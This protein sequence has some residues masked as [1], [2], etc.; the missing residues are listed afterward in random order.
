MSDIR[1][2]SF[3][4]NL[5]KKIAA[6]IFKSVGL[7]NQAASHHQH[8]VPHD[9]GWAIKG[10]GNSRYTEIFDRQSAAI[11][12]ATEIAENYKADVIIHGKDG[13]IRDRRSYR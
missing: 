11:E 13:T 9:Q 6:I 10:E 4:T 8:V 2:E 7:K 3:W 5:V 12:R 1:Q